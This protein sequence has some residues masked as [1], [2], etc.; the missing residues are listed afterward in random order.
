MGHKIFVRDALPSAYTGRKLDPR[1]IRDAVTFTLDAEDVKFPCDV[2]VTL[3]DDAGIRE[4]N[5]QYREI[6]T[7]T[8]VL[9]FPLQDFAPSEYAMPEYDLASKRVP[10]GDIVLSVERVAAQAEEYGNTQG[11]EATYLTVHST[12]H[13][14]GYDHTDEGADK[15]LMRAREKEI[16]RAL[17]YDDAIDN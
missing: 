3:T 1:N 12:L 14:L 2:S 13:L 4:I 17:G 7:A 9:S 6:D 15:Q 8:D 16:M 10:L 5:A 11:R